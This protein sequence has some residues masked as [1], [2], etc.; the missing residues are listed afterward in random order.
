MPPLPRDLRVLVR[1]WLDGNV[2]LVHGSSPA[3]VD[4]GYH[5]GVPALLDWLASEGHTPGTLDRIVLTHVHSDHAGGVAA[6]RPPRAARSRSS[7]M[8]MPGR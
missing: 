1:G 4:T 3:L 5:T 8:P 2:V 7:P 6:C